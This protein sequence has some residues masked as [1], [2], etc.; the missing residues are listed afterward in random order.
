MS[1]TS[2]KIP[3]FNLNFK[4]KNEIL[5]RKNENIFLPFNMNGCF[6]TY[7]NLMYGVGNLKLTEFLYTNHFDTYCFENDKD[8][9]VYFEM[10][11]NNGIDIT[12][13]IGSEKVLIEKK[14]FTGKLTKYGKKIIENVLDINETLKEIF[15]MKKFDLIIGNPPY[16]L[17]HA[18]DQGYITVLDKIYDNSDHIIWICPARWSACSHTK[19]QNVLDFRKKCKLT[20]FDLIG[21]PF[22]NANVENVGIFE[23]NKNIDNNINISDVYYTRFSNKEIASKILNKMDEYLK[24]H[25]SMKTIMNSNNKIKLICPMLRGNIHNGVKAW[26]WTTIVSKKDA[27]K[28]FIFGFNTKNEKNNFLVYV[29]TDIIYFIIFA[30]KDD[31]NNTPYIFSKIP[32]MNNYNIIWTDKMIADEIGLT[33]EEVDYIH[34]EMKNFGWK[35]APRKTKPETK[36][37]M[38]VSTKTQTKVQKLDVVTKEQIKKLQIKGLNLVTQIKKKNVAMFSRAYGVEWRKI[39]KKFP[40]NQALRSYNYAK[41]RISVAKKFI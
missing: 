9:I 6:G 8:C 15:K 25:Y 20:S 3:L 2:F 27:K 18:A 1:F 22:K 37:K 21:N 5:E 16:S 34:E 17:V 19:Q 10:L 13:H 29:N 35:A 30:T 11:K 4:S 39:N 28:G 14:E 26:D 24:N 23:F 12:I 7:N 31:R 33:E 32:L 36:G 41:A 40:D 38:N